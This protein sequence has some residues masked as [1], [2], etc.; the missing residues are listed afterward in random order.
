MAKLVAAAAAARFPPGFLRGNEEPVLLF[1]APLLE[2]RLFVAD[3]RLLTLDIRLEDALTGELLVLLLAVNPVL[4]GGSGNGLP[5]E[6]TPLVVSRLEERL[7]FDKYA[8]C[9][10]VGLTPVMN[11]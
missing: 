1:E 2:M 7:L 10:A 11:S 3:W 6:E 8:R 9:R 4:L 5:A